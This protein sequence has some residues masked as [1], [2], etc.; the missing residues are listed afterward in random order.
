MGMSV[1]EAAALQKVRWQRRKELD[2]LRAAKKRKGPSYLLF[3]RI[4]DEVDIK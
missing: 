3:W 4:K 2:E 1:E